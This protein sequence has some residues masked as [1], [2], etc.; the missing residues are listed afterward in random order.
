MISNI[1]EKNN[2]FIEII[3]LMKQSS[4]RDG[5]QEI[6]SK[7]KTNGKSERKDPLGNF[8]IKSS[9]GIPHK[10]VVVNAIQ[11][12]SSSNKNSEQCE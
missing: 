8:V 12:E 3:N 5:L 11:E 6:I 1:M 9:H 2:N 4:K 10:D 7:P